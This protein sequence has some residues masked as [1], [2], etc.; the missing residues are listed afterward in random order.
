MA[1]FFQQRREALQLNETEMAARCGSTQNAVR[2]WELDKC[3]PRPRIADLAKAY[4]VDVKKMA[5]EVIALRLRAESNR[6]LAAAK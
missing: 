1:N 2:A 5:S 6:P 3:V 4:E